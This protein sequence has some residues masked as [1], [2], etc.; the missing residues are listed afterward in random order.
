ME[1]TPPP[2]AFEADCDFT[3]KALATIFPLDNKQH[4]VVALPVTLSAAQ[5]KHSLA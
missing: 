4:Q 1:Q 2:S 5:Q 3:I